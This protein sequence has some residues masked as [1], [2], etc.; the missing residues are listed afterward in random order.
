MIFESWVKLD[1]PRRFRWVY[2]VSCVVIE[3]KKSA[4]MGISESTL[5]KSCAS[6]SPQYN[7]V[8]LTRGRVTTVE[9][10]KRPELWLELHDG[11]G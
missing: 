10:S 1:Y 11:A 2:V 7:Q 9:S 8:M 6:T 3:T 4:S 5:D